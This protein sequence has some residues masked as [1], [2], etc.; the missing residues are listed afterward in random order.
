MGD[1]LRLFQELS[2]GIIIFLENH[3]GV[4]Q[5]IL[6]MYPMQSRLTL[7]VKT[8]SMAYI[9]AN[10]QLVMMIFGQTTL[11]HF[12]RDHLWDCPVSLET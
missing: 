5:N 2:T 4:R 1:C 6:S 3:F 9:I 11:A 12:G 10:L 8:I 7:S